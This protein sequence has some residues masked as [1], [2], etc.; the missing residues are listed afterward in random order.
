MGRK[1]RRN[2]DSGSV[3]DEADVITM[4]EWFIYDLQGPTWVIGCMIIGSLLGFIVGK[5]SF[6]ILVNEGGEVSLW[7]KNLARRIRSSSPF[8]MATS[9]GTMWDD[10]KDRFAEWV[11]DMER[12]IQLE[13]YAQNPLHPRVFAVLRE[14][15]VRE[16]GGYVHPDLG[17]MSPSPSGAHR[18]L[19]MVRDSYHNCQIQCVPGIADEKEDDMK[20][21]IELEKHNQT[22][23]PIPDK[24]TFRQE[25]V[26][27]KVPLEFQMTRSVALDVLMTQ[28]P[29]EVQK[30]SNMHELDDAAFLVLLLANERGIGRFSRWMPYIASLPSQPSCGYSRELRPY[31]LDA[32]SAYNV[33][34]GV[35][36]Q[37]WP[38]ELIKAT[39]YA[40][41]IA[42]NLASD[43]SQFISH[44]TGV[45]P[46]DNIRW[47]LCQVA[48][49]ATA[50]SE[51]H[52]ALRLI[53]IL[54]LINHDANAA[55]FIELTGKERYTDGA[56]VETT[57]DDSGTFVVRSLRH[58]RRKALQKGQELM[59]NY[60]VP[61]YSPL[62]WFV[63]LGF[64][65]PERWGAWEKI[66]PALPRLRTDGP[67]AEESTPS[68][69]YW[70][71]M[72]PS[73]MEELR[74]VEL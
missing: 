50:G 58:G 68:S 11:A 43:Y 26:L 5:G 66:E 3:T 20:L 30:K 23:P 19:G 12:D 14:A 61:E 22:C 72:G 69:D 25:E 53:P 32:L 44:P 31:M 39:D 1:S 45:E 9:Q 27:L 59:V 38:A 28:V 17:I 48:S 57:E 51:Q 16:K 35:D 46:V 64:V 52:G 40:D 6:G 62:D 56:F 65:P 33:E 63:S 42:Q 73:I 54:D 18:G 15:V 10:W 8:Q 24:P 71:E 55:E 21:R 74:K 4:K 29:I 34:V 36:T 2:L 67:F 49:R 37:G 60:N 41:K 13:E 7:R 47:A 70:E